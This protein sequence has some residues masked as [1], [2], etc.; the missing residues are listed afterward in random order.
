MPGCKERW[1]GE[2]LRKYVKENI[3]GAIVITRKPTNNYAMVIDE[4]T[5]RI[6]YWAE[7]NFSLMEQ[8]TSPKEGE[9]EEETIQPLFNVPPQIDVNS[10]SETLAINVLSYLTEL[11]ELM[12][13]RKCTIKYDDE[14]FPTKIVCGPIE[15][16]F[17]G[18]KKI[19]GEE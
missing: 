16:T 3:P 14:G 1:S 11:T 5:G 13:G 4:K 7:K 17:K 19:K 9:K 15:F 6:L 2:D 8:L 10:L 12:G 18:R